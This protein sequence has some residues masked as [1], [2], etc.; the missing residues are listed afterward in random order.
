MAEK[1]IAANE[2]KPSHSYQPKMAK[3]LEHDGKAVNGTASQQQ[4]GDE[5][6]TIKKTW[7]L[8]NFDIG[9]PLGRGKLS[10]RFAECF[11]S[12]RFKIS[13]I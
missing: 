6:S 11:S 1:Q 5:P 8:S 10:Q 2:A 12:E 3:M 9:R 13:I 4:N 7:E